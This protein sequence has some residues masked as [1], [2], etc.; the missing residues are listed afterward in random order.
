MALTAT[1]LTNA[2][3]DRAIT[4]LQENRTRTFGLKELLDK[5]TSNLLDSGEVTEL[6]TLD[7]R[8]VQIPVLNRLDRDTSFTDSRSC[9][10]T[11]EDSVSALQAI[12]WNTAT[13]YTTITPVEHRNNEIGME[14]K[15]AHQLQSGIRS[16]LEDI[17]TK[18][19][20][21][22]NANKSQ[23]LTNS[24]D[25]IVPFNT[26]NDELQIAYTDRAE[27]WNYI[28]YIMRENAFMPGFNVASSWGT[29]PSVDYYKN[30]GQANSANL[31]YQFGEYDFYGSVGVTNAGGN[32]GTFF[33]M[34]KGSVAIVYW[35]SPQ[36]KMGG[37]SANDASG[38]MTYGTADVPMIGQM[39]TKEWHQCVDISGT[40]TGV[41][42]AEQ[43]KTEYSIDYAVIPLYNSD[44]T[45]QASSIVKG[46]IQEAAGGSS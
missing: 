15:F 44:L 2:R 43:I 18:A 30:Q 17:E 35:V 39:A 3:T 19:Y 27:M 14:R 21:M 36:G 25:S 32:L 8:T 38:K 28:K 7:N 5:D 23:V 13:F 9:N 24:M 40:Y 42:D 37:D 22:L 34:P 26:T 45:T 29:M 16:V 33:V 11:V 20:T 6:R 46:V 1:L 10:P 12:T 31:S 4:D 41:T